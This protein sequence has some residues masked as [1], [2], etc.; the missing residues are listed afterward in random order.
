[1]A[2]NEA[3]GENITIINA[4][5]EWGEGMH[6]EPDK[7]DGVKWLEAVKKAKE[8]YGQY[9]ERYK[10]ENEQMSES[11][12]DIYCEKEKISIYYS[13]INKWMTIKEK[14]R[15]AI[16]SIKERLD[17]GII[18]YGSGVLTDHLIWECK[19]VGISVK[20][21]IDRAS[22]VN[23]EGISVFKVEDEWPEADAI[24]VTAF[25][26]M[27]DI[28]NSVRK[29]NKDILIYSLDEIIAMSE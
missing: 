14:G 5:N 20:G 24:I 19:E 21:I 13:V 27:R 25:Y 1:M 23:L 18:I 9:V 15:L 7:K 29:V 22:V 10:N 16:D 8:E 11:E 2:K 12:Y 4:W 28:C 6:L 3:A 26:H 17:N